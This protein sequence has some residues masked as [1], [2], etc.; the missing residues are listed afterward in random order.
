MRLSVE[1]EDDMAAVLRVVHDPLKVDLIVVRDEHAA[2][3][4]IT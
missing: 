1:V 2:L 4:T 3:R